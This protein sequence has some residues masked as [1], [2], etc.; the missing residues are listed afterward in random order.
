MEQ[1]SGGNE[2]YESKSNIRTSGLAV[3]VQLHINKVL[4]QDWLS[5]RYLVKS[6]RQGR[7]EVKTNNVK[8]STEPW[9]STAVATKPMN[10]KARGEEEESFLVLV[11]RSICLPEKEWRGTEARL[12]PSEGEKNWGAS[13]NL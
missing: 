5:T 2:A 8:D 6:H 3:N 10:S 11:H 9:S 13:S 7:M 4:L 12:D 1:C